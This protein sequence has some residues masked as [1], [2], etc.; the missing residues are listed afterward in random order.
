[1]EAKDMSKD[2]LGGEKTPEQDVEQDALFQQ[3]IIKTS[4]PTIAGILLITAGLIALLF[5]ILAATANESI[6]NSAMNASQSQFSKFNLTRGQLG[7][8]LIICETVGGVIAVFSILAGVLSLKRKIWGLALVA[9]MP[10]S[11]LGVIWLI[12]PGSSP[13]LAFGLLALIGLFLIAFS[14]RE[15]Q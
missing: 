8:T 12:V 5:W 11:L 4:K 3:P 13:M 2:D 7:E 14:R 9:S 15:F 6:I 10:Q 1:V